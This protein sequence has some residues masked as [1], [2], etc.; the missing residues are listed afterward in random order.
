MKKIFILITVMLM[1]SATLVVNAAERPASTNSPTN[2]GGTTDPLA[3]EKIFLKT[4]LQDGKLEEFTTKW[5]AQQAKREENNANFLK[6]VE[7]YAPEMLSQYETAFATHDSVHLELFNTR[8][9]IYTAFANE[10]TAQL[11]ILKADIDAKLTAKEITVKEARDMLKTFWSER[12]AQI[13]ANTEA[14]KVAI[15]DEKAA[16]EVRVQEV[17]LIREALKVAI[18]EE[19]L[20]TITSSINALYPYLQAHIAF[21]EFKLATMNNMF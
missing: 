19:D 17:K 10:T 5:N 12:K 11:Q 16:Q 2:T 4:A 6:L 21:D 18:Q 1:L 20:E 8:I 15:A 7:T 3:Q 9:D 14:Y 13:K